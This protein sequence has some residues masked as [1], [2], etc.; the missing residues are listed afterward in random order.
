MSKFLY[1]KEIE[2]IAREYI[3]AN[4]SLYTERLK[5]IL[6]KVFIKGYEANKGEIK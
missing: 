3:N 5:E 6:V 2:K 1:D 4:F